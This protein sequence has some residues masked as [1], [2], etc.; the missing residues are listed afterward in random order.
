LT[1]SSKFKSCNIATFFRLPQQ[2]QKIK[3]NLKPCFSNHADK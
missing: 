2:K 1:H 3:G